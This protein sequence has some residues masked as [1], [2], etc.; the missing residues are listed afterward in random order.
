MIGCGDKPGGMKLRSRAA[1]IA[2]AGLVLTI[3]KMSQQAEARLF[4]F[5][6]FV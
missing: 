2:I 5:I 3:S 4:A 6:L 1:C